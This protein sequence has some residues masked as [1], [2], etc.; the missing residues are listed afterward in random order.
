MTAQQNPALPDDFTNELAR[1]SRAGFPLLPLGGGADGKAPLLRSWAGPKMTLSRVLAPLYRSGS[2]VYGVRLD[3]L[4]VIDCDEN[5]PELVAAIE[6]RFGPSPVHVKTPRGRHLYYRA[7]GKAPNLR[8]EGLPVDIKTG[9]RAY[10]VGPL[11]ERPDGGQYWPAKGLLGVDALPLLR[12]P[13]GPPSGN[14][15]PSDPIPVGHRHVRL[16]KEAVQMVELVDSAE[17]LA[18]N[19]AGV[20]D[21]FCEDAST[22][23]D[24]ELAAIA[25]WAW[26]C[27]LD[28]RVYKGRDSAFPLQRQ[29]LDALRG[30]DNDTDAITLYVMLVDLHG[31]SPGKRFALD[32]KAMRASGLTRLSI[33][34]LRAARRN[35][36]T[37]GLL[38]QVGK[39]RAGSRHQTW[40]LSRLRPS[41]TH[42]ESVT[43]IKP[44]ML[45]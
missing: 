27:R 21:D 16:I 40:A 3:G 26:Q 8:G 43:Q 13:S 44:E 19:L 20:R 37:V 33:P 5:S 28:N 1:L 7:N 31:H 18:A 36:Q 17:E 23:P 10:V 30:C 2:Q 11:S 4:A 34:R 29:A 39:H 22:M 12:A 9:P 6:A 42:A 25:G 32:F 15:G 41:S 24:S 38:V 45:S 35:L 14:V